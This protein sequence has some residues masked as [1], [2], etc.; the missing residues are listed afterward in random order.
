LT[1]FKFVSASQVNLLQK[2]LVAG[3]REVAQSL[4]HQ[5]EPIILIR[6]QEPQ[7]GIAVFI[8]NF[9]LRLPPSLIAPDLSTQILGNGTQ[10]S[11]ERRSKIE[12]TASSQF[13]QDNFERLLPYVSR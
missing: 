9:T 4:A 11:G 2:Q 10:E 3:M 5:L 6:F 7:H 13:F 12:S 1:Q 8:R